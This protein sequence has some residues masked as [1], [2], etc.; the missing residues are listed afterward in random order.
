MDKIYRIIW[1]DDEIDALLDENSKALL[2]KQHV[3][4]IKCNNAAMLEEKLRNVNYRIDAVIV[5]ANF[6]ARDFTPSNET[7]VSGLRKAMMLIGE[8]KHLPFYL[9]TQ[10]LNLSDLVDEDELSYFKDNNAIFYKG[11]GLLPLLNRI[12]NDVD[13]YNSAEFQIDNQF[14]KELDYFQ[15]FDKQCDAKSHDL[16][17]ELFIQ[18][19]EGSLSEAE[20]YF[21]Q[22][23]SEILENMN[24]VAAHFGIVPKGLSLNDFSRFLCSKAEKYKLKEEVLPKA[25]HMLMEYVVRM[26]QDGSHKRGNIQYGVHQFVSKYKD[27]LIIQSLLF[28]IIELMS[29][30]IPYL[31]THTDIQQNLEN[32]Q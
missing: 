25:L 18:S 5:D 23:R 14:K 32:W 30:F 13:N 15:V 7:V 6:T 3:E 9:Y 2:S 21:N 19:R 1:A 22:F 17:R 29:W 27:T 16:V 12:K 20:S 24:A 8:F 11:N 10:R 4:V 26:V 28:A 31:A